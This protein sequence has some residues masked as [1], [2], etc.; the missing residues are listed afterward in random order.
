[1]DAREDQATEEQWG[2]SDIRY[3]GKFVDAR[4]MFMNL[5]KPCKTDNIAPLLFIRMPLSEI[6][7]NYG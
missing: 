2:R 4:R 3:E 7:R 5:T 6:R 1:M